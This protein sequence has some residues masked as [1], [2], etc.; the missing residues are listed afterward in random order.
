[1]SDQKTL[2]DAGIN[3]AK[4]LERFMKNAGLYQ[5]FLTKFLTDA[6]YTGFKAALESGDLTQAEKT[7]H[8]LKGTAGNLS[9]DNLY[10]L[11]DT[12][13]KKIRGG[14]SLEEVKKLEPELDAMYE[15]VCT[16]IRS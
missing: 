12:I 15:K 6:S 11:A 10:T 13:V 16:A 9:I 14:A 2:E 1:M 7:I 5:K 4:G 8:T 3:Y